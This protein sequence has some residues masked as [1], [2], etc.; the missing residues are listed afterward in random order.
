M[1][2]AFHVPE[3]LLIVT[4]KG[5][6]LAMSES[7]QQVAQRKGTHLANRLLDPGVSFNN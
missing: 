1:F 7:E 3:H 4:L 6:V 5:H 2:V